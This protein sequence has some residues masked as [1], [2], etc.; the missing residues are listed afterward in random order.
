M[1]Q[2]G[3]R[4]LEKWVRFCDGLDK[5][6]RDRLY[7]LMRYCSARGI[8]PTSIDDE[9]LQQVAMYFT[10]IWEESGPLFAFAFAFCLFSLSL[11]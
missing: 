3:A 10:L 4:L 8:G 7:S 6:I 9:I 2:R 1:P 11:R 5:R